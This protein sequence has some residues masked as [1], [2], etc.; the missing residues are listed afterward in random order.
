MHELSVAQ[1]IIDAIKNRVGANNPLSRISLTI[2][3]LSG[4]SA[5]SLEFWLSE[6]AKQDGFGSPRVVIEK[7]A[8]WAICSACK[9]KYE[10]HSFYSPCPSCDS[11][12]RTIASGVE[13]LIDSIEV[14]DNENV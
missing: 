1:S 6:I 7:K 11:F 5:E 2:G 4:I 12:E 10:I 9:A 8:A 13:C 3:P 14:E